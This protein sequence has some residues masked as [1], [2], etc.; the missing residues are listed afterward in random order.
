MAK[1]KLKSS[2]FKSFNKSTFLYFFTIFFT[3]CFF[4][5]IYECIKIYQ[6]N[7]VK[8]IKKDFKRKLMKDSL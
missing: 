2:I 5:Y 1:L 7:I 6:L 3:I 8:K 4:A